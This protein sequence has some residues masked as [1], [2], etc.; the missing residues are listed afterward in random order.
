MHDQGKP[1]NLLKGIYRSLSPD[2]VY[3]MQDIKAT[4][5]IRGNIGHVLGTFLYTVSTLHCMTVS[6]A[7]GGE[8]LGAMWGEQKTREYLAAA[9]F[10]SVAKHEIAHDVMNN[11]YVVRK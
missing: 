3:L 11:W 10:G 5:D 1:L 8:G 7:Q 4:T 6:L 2:G 9:G